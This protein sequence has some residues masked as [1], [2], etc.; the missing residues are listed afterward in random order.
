MEAAPLISVIVP[1]Y[2]VR[3][4]FLRECF[5]SILKQ[6]LDDFEL[7]IVDDGSPEDNKK[8]IAEYAAGDSRIRT[9]TQENRGV[10]VARNEGIRAA[11]G[12]YI[13]FIDSDDTVREDNLQLITDA[14]DKNNLDV[15]MWGMYR[16]F[17]DKKVEFSPYLEDIDLFDERLRKEV[18]LKCLVGTLP[19]F[20]SPPASVDAAGSACAK[21]YRRDFLIENSLEYTPNLKRAEDMTFNLKVFYKAAG[22]G[23]LY[24]FLY[25]Y[26]QLS[27]SATYV[28]RP[29]GIQ[30]FTD[31]LIE[32]RRFLDENEA[33]ELTMQVYYMRCMFFFLESMDMDYMN[34]HND[35]PLIKRLAM[36][37]KAASL[38]PYKEA[39]ENLKGTHLV[40]SRKIP[41]FLI[42]NGLFALLALFYKTWRL[43]QR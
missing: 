9:I 1:V 16:C 27:S 38:N 22:I 43:L 26:R 8:I 7:I 3:E 21:L 18:I 24:D 4:Q 33:D 12:R 30:V 5:D 19:F 20:K 28:Y 37:R 35:K 2:K 6:T 23:Y 10:A 14:A 32:M 42:R 31:S 25:N 29:G 40:F 36:M 39:F 34:P 41:L 15:L 11:R 13:T 17:D